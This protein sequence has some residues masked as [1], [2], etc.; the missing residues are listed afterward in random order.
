MTY[1]PT[2][3]LQK[4]PGMFVGDSLTAA[5]YGSEEDAIAKADYKY[6]K[7]YK[8]GASSET[9]L[10]YVESAV[11]LKPPFIS[12]LA[13]TNDVG[14]NVDPLPNIKKMIALCQAK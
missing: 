8:I 6:G 11:R 13:G 3:E 9:I 4:L 5:M 1:N 14:N 12:I 7:Y 10:G 2:N